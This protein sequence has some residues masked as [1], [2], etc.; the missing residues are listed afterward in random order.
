E[1]ERAREKLYDELATGESFSRL[2][3]LRMDVDNLGDLFIRRVPEKQ[4]NLA[5]YATLSSQLDMFFS[6]YLNVIRKKENYRNHVNIL[7]AGGDDVFAIGRW[8]EIVDFSLEI[9]EA[10]RRFIGGRGD[11]TL[12]AGIS[13]VGGKFPISK[14]ADLAGEA[15][16]EAKKY[17][18]NGKIH[19]DAL[20]FLETTLSWDEFHEIR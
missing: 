2:G 13:L 19:K 4:R 6:G 8:K 5:T 10:F 1:A 14:A 20:T 16:A 7:Y 9:R 3:I 11:I 18:G 15:E 17:M 12:S